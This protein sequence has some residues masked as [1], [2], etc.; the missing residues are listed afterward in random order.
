MNFQ[1]SLADIETTLK[2]DWNHVQIKVYKN[3]ELNVNSF[4]MYIF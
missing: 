2:I 4:F 1:I 3:L